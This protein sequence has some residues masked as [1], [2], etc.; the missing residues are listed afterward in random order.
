ML[1]LDLPAHAVRQQHVT[2]PIDRNLAEGALHERP[3]PPPPYASRYECRP[4]DERECRAE[5][6]PVFRLHFS[7]AL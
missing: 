4:G 2:E 1:N 7:F 3:V 6:D 5:Q